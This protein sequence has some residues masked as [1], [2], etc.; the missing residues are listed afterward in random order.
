MSYEYEIG[1]VAARTLRRLAATVREVAA[2]DRLAEFRG[3]AS[4]VELAAR[5][6][7]RAGER[8]LADELRKI[9]V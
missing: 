4:D 7:E 2:L 5:L 9:P 3:S 6:Y 8:Q 1:R